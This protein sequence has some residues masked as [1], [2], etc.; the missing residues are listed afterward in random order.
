MEEFK[1]HKHEVPLYSLNKVKDYEDLEKWINDMKKASKDLDF[2]RAA[3]LRDEIIR[4][5]ICNLHP[6]RQL[7]QH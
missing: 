5:V 4:S 1:K 7:R 3:M 2:E 6:T